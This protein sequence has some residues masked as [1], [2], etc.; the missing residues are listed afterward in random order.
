MT[1]MPSEQSAARPPDSHGRLGPPATDH[2]GETAE[3]Q[4][5][6]V[7]N[8]KAVERAVSWSNDAIAPKQGER[9]IPHG[10]ERTGLRQ[11]SSAGASTVPK[12]AQVDG[13][14]RQMIAMQRAQNAAMRQLMSTEPAAGRV[15]ASPSGLRDLVLLPC[16]VGVLR[17]ESV[18]GTC[19]GPA[20]VEAVLRPP[21]VADP[22]DGAHRSPPA[23]PGERGVRLL[24]T[25]LTPPGLR[26]QRYDAGGN[27]LDVVDSP[28]SYNSMLDQMQYAALAG[29]EQQRCAVEVQLEGTIQTSTARTSCQPS[30]S[31]LI[32][33]YP[34]CDLEGALRG[35]G[36]PQISL[37][38]PTVFDTQLPPNGHPG[39]P[40]R[41][42]PHASDYGTQ[43]DVHEDV[44][45][46]TAHTR[47]AFHYGSNAEAGGPETRG[48]PDVEGCYDASSQLLRNRIQRRRR[49]VLIDL[50]CHPCQ[51]PSRADHLLRS[52]CSGAVD[53]LLTGAGLLAALAGLGLVPRADGAARWAPVALTLAAAVA[54]GACLA[55][56]HV[57]SVRLGAGERRELRREEL[58]GLE[59]RRA[60][61]KARLVDALLIQGVLK[62]DAMSLADTLEG[63]PELF[64][65]AL[66][67][68]GICADGSEGGH[69]IGYGDGSQPR[70]DGAALGVPPP[71]Y[72]PEMTTAQQRLEYEASRDSDGF[73]DDSDLKS[74][75]QAV[76]ESAFEGLCM[77]LSFSS[78]SVIPGLIYVFLP[79][80]VLANADTP[81]DL[82]AIMLSLCV[83][84]AIMFVLGIWKR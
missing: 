25:V 41:Q 24:P 63:Y 82:L 22:K 2:S 45:P 18:R 26:P 49:G 84:A 37:T 48:A 33:R 14:L 21:P 64:V 4:H 6:V 46:F 8:M 9:A 58:H 65:S 75:S 39:I 61:A 10:D 70:M 30:S 31:L 28:A 55:V 36:S 54:D 72:T 34:R 11:S 7:S 52:S 19:E 27:D 50:L 47:H 43:G 80:L 13:R 67:G 60:D 77:M 73:G 17:P 83:L 20:L 16:G 56:G 79:P 74:S 3:E 32:E 57:W 53:G 44:S 15:S 59:W 62:I 76:S 71:C 29:A 35:G 81:G 68:G 38:K 69:A 42:H 12:S 40:A 1:I 66:L 51:G 5:P 78:F 23:R